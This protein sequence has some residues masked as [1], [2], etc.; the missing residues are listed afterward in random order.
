MPHDELVR[1]YQRL[2]V[3]GQLRVLAGFGHDLTIAARDTYDVQAPGVRAPE[4][5]RAINE[6]QH[7]ILGHIVALM[8][9]EA[10]RYPDDVLLAI[11]LE[12]DD[13]EGWRAQV[14]QAFT[15]ALN[16]VAT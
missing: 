9:A 10:S 14:R 4:R 2:P 6:L 8:N 5:L 11:V 7:Q 12:D 15:H 1:R 13:D 16:R 3:G